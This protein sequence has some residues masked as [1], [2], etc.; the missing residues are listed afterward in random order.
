MTSITD[1]LLFNMADSKTRF[2]SISVSRRQLT[3]Q[4]LIPSIL[5]GGLAVLTVAGLRHWCHMN[6]EGL[7]TAA[8]LKSDD[9]KARHQKCMHV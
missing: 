5:P 1:L 2:S 7:L 4:A 9:L 6:L 3:H 8:R